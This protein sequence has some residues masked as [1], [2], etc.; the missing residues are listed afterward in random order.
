MFTIKEF[1]KIEVKPALGCTEPGAVALGVAR[2]VEALE[3]QEPEKIEV[4]VSDSIYKNGM[5]VGIPG[6]S[7]LKGNDIAAALGAICGKSEYGLEVLKDCT[8]EAVKKANKILEEKMVSIIPDL[9]RHGVYVEALVN[10]GN[11]NAVCVIEKTHSNITTVMKDSQVIYDGQNGNNNGN[12]KGESIP[13]QVSRMNYREIVSLADGM[14]EEDVNHVMDGAEMNFKIASYGFDHDSGIN[15]GS[16]IR[17]LAGDHYD[18][19]DLSSKIKAVSAAASDARMDGAPL[20]VMSSAGSGNHGITAIIPVAVAGKHY[21][22]TREETA[23]AIAFSHLTTSFIKSRMG[24]LS[25]V[26]GCSVAAGAGSAAGIVKLLGGDVKTAVKAIEM[27]I[28]NLVGMLCDGAK[29]TCS[30]KV[31]TGASEAYYA[32]MLALKGNGLTVPQGVID[33]TIEKTV[34]NAA[35]V[36]LEGMK[37][38]DSILINIISKRFPQ[39]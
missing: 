1:L 15:L 8:E 4:T 30:L 26:C 9:S 24:R 28:G 12:G 16:T 7:G 36:N 20:P 21:G 17:E 29:E 14:D 37:D 39:A 18:S 10:A 25:P 13:D 6:T 27:V 38:V 35:R 34:E 3:G 31:G 23:K 33:D 2:A 32:A 19:D 22:K 11:S 5:Y